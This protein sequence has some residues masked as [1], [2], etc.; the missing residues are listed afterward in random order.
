[1][2]LEAVHTY[3]QKGVAVVSW[4]L[5]ANEAGDP[6]EITR[7]HE[8]CVQIVDDPGTSTVTIEGS[9]DGV[10]WAA[11]N[12]KAMDADS[13][14]PLSAL[15]DAGIHTILENPMYIRPVTADGDTN[16]IGVILVGVAFD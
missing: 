8:K 5:D 13:A 2:A 11:L 3:P 1:M 6:A 10:T 15:A 14:I 16:G 4:S 7:W 12:S 9:N